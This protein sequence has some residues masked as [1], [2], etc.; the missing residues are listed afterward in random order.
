MTAYFLSKPKPPCF[1]LL[2]LLIINGSV[3][4]QN[5]IEVDKLIASDRSLYDGLGEAV[6]VDGDYAFVC[7]PGDD[8]DELGNNFMVNTG[9]VYIYKRDASSH[10][11]EIQKIVASDRAPNDVFGTSVSVSGRYAVIGAQFGHGD[12]TS[13]NYQSKT[14]AAYI[15]ERQTNGQW[16]EIQKI[17]SSDS[18]NYDKFA[19]SVSISGQY[20]IVGARFHRYDLS[21]G[22]Y[23]LNSGAAYLFEQNSNGLWQ[24][25]QKLISSQRV[26]SEHYGYSVSISGSY[27]V[28]GAY[29]YGGDPGRAYLIERDPNGLW[30]EKQQITALDGGHFDN[31]GSAVS[32]SGS[33]V[34]IGASFTDTDTS[35]LNDVFSA[36][37]AYMFERKSTGIWTKT[38]KIVPM[39][40]SY[41]A[42]FGASVSIS[43]NKAIVGAPKV[44]LNIQG[45]D[46]LN[47]AG[48][49]YVFVK[50][51]QGEWEEKQKMIAS[52][53]KKGDWFG[54]AVSISND[55]A[56]MGASNGQ[57]TNGSNTIFRAGAAYVFEHPPCLNSTFSFSVVECESYT[58]PSSKATFT[59]VGSYS[60]SDT[61]VN[62][63]GGDSILTIN[64]T[65]LPS[66]TLSIATTICNY[67]SIVVNGTI[68]NATHPSGVEIIP[69]TGP[70]NCDS[71]ITVNLN[72]L[73]PKMDSLSYILCDG[74]SVL[75]NGTTYNSNHLS[76]VETFTGVGP[77]YCDS[78]VYVDLAKYLHMEINVLPIGEVCKNEAQDVSVNMINGKPPY[79]YNWGYGNVVGNGEVFQFY[80]QPNQE[81]VV[82]LEVNDFCVEKDSIELG[83]IVTNCELVIPNIFTPNGD[84]I[85]E[86]FHI[87]GLQYFSSNNLAVYDRWGV[88]LFEQ[89]NYRNTWDGYKCA[90]GVYYYV[91]VTTKNGIQNTHQGNI[92]LLK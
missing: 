4:G 49:A 64:V 84:G 37:A 47:R 80:P 31:F 20:I 74:D 38:Q 21:N 43:G 68:Y 23:L 30:V 79:A 7:A 34:I 51:W 39:D 17:A 67:D 78:I 32:I 40:R 11:S 36:G 60:V 75:V 16:I 46:S 15:F 3:L 91:L 57:D 45:L 48:A 69:N 71:T 66:K 82:H 44:H 33:H 2:I 88:L 85:N 59:T 35:G 83:I 24:Q 26:G 13:A 42:E 29:L 61:L 58:V 54:K 25:K 81:E 55:Y 10:W 14:G 8:V 5:F 9:S 70:Y 87:E 73:A 76:G 53:R 89:A 19:K 63:C 56:V 65:I 18:R 1:I 72:V 52:D 12:S 62:H 28:V 92:T 22:N 77:F 27:A 6:W 90:E 41:F 50:N 86:Y